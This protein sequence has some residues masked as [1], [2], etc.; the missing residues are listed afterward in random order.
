MKD[1]L[2]MKL[3]FYLIWDG[4]KEK[5][6]EISGDYL[7]SKIST[8]FFHHIIPKSTDKKLKYC[9]ENIV[10][11]TSNEH[12]QVEGD[13]YKF[14]IVNEKRTFI[15]DNYEKMCEDSKEMEKILT[16]YLSDKN[17]AEQI[18]QFFNTL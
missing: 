14:D 17:N 13:I 18:K 10:V 12:I 9:V 7:G 1:S 6:S 8:S 4:L 3:F 16:H 11:L 5:R 15:N 2:K